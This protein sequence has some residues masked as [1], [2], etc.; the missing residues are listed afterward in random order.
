MMLC[1][2]RSLSRPYLASLSMS[3]SCSRVRP[4]PSSSATLQR[5]HKHPDVKMKV[6]KDCNPSDPPQSG[7]KRIMPK[8]TAPIRPLRAPDVPNLSSPAAMGA[9]TTHEGVDLHNFLVF[10]GWHSQSKLQNVFSNLI[11][12]SNL[13]SKILYLKVARERE[14][15]HPYRTSASGS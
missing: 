1:G 11:R 13:H 3:R 10:L 6:N 7:P 15:D 8:L 2:V 14:R 12:T 4:P 9:Q 5:R